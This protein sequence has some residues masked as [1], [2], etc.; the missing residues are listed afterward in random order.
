MFSPIVFQRLWN[1]AVEPVKW[2]PAKSG[3]LS[4]TRLTSTASPGTK[5]MTPGGSPASCSRRIEV[6]VAERG[7]GRGLPDHGVAHQRGRG[8]QVPADGGEVERRDG[9][10]EAFEGPVVHPVPRPRHRLG[11]LL[12]DPLGER[13]VE[14]Q[15]VDQLAGAVDLGLEGGLALA[16][17]G[18]RVDQLAALPGE[19]VRGAEED[20]GPV[21]EAPVGP[22]AL[23]LDRRPH[24]RLDGGGIGVVDLGENPLVAV[25]RDHVVG[26]AAADFLPADHHGDIHLLGRLA[27]ERR[28][29]RGPLRGARGIAQHRLV[30][31]SGDVGDTAH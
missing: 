27:L 12:V 2:I 21:L 4:S 5:L 10:D 22:V 15:E 14:P 1:T 7:R 18:G 24:G 25:G 30:A 28:L 13:D 20:R 16:Q 8:G 19:Q 11:L 6:P 23:G 17:H 31:G 29:E 26:V 3:S 9:V